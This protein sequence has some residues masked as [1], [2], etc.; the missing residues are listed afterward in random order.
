M[1]GLMLWAEKDKKDKAYKKIAE[2]RKSC[3]TCNGLGYAV[4]GI[5]VGGGYIG[6]RTEHISCWSCG[7]L[8]LSY[9]IH[10]EVPDTLT[11]IVK[12]ESTDV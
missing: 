11:K 4:V 3:K 10:G 2:L 8:E 6:Y 5:G 12:P 9:E 1:Y 7:Y